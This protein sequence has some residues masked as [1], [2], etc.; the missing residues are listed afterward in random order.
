MG[1]DVR[2]MR[3]C[4]AADAGGLTPLMVA[5]TLLG[6]GWTM[7]GL[8]PLLAAPRTRRLGAVLGVSLAATAALVFVVKRLV[9]RVRPCFALPGVRPLWD[10]PT[11]SSFPSG[12]AAGSFAVAAFVVGLCVAAE[13]GRPERVSRGAKG[14]LAVLAVVV[15]GGVALSRVYLGV[16][17]PSD[18]AGG[19]LL[20]SLAGAA[21]AYVFLK[22]A[23]G[24]GTTRG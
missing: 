24:E 21:A 9:H 10:T 15:A 1:L 14:A 19:A 17:F 5:L 11:D 12:H 22:G 16:H 3:L 20:G 6:S 7:L 8:L 4:Y 13:W 23:P 2:L 18:V